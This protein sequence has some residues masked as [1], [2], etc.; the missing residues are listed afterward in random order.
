MELALQYSGS[1]VGEISAPSGGV[2]SLALS[3]WVLTPHLCLQLPQT[4]GRSSEATLSSVLAPGIEGLG[5]RGY[6]VHSLNFFSF[7]LLADLL[8]LTR[9]ALSMFILSEL[10]KLGEK[11]CCRAQKAQTPQE[12]VCTLTQVRY[13]VHNNR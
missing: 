4:R 1:R 9:L 2:D 12:D 6:A 3:S 10:F 8:L 7:C 5:T 13:L 11:F